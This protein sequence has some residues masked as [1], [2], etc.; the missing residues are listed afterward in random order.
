MAPP[1]EDSAHDAR[2]RVESVHGLYRQAF[3]N[4]WG[5]AAA[6]LCLVLVMWPFG[7]HSMLLGWLAV[8]LLVIAARVPLV[9]SYA[10]DTSRDRRPEVWARRYTWMVLANGS[11]WALASLL[12]LREGDPLAA[13][14]F[15]MIVGLLAAGS[16]ASQSYHLPAVLGFVSLA[17]LPLMLRLMTWKDWDYLPAAVTLLLFFL[18]LVA[19][20]RIQNRRI[21]DGIALRM[22]NQDL[23]AAL[24]REKEES[25]LQRARAEQ[26]SL[27][28]SQFLAA[29]SHDLRQPMHALGLFS[30]SLREAAKDAEQHAMV[31][32]ISASIESLES[33]FTELLDLSRLD[34]GYMQAHLVDIPLERVLGQLH[35]Q[36]A[37]L[38]TAKGLALTMDANGTVIRSDPVLLE[39]LLGNLVANAIQYTEHGR[40]SVSAT[41][42]GADIVVEVRD[43]GIGIPAA[44]RERVFDEFFQ[45]G[46][47]ERDRR[48]GLGLG[49]AI[50]RRLS[51]MLNHPVTLA[52]DEGKGSRFSVRIPSGD[53]QAVRPAQ[54]MPHLP[55][56]VLRG[57]VIL[58]LDNEISIRRGMEALL[59]R[60][61]CHVLSAGSEVEAVA[62]ATQSPPDLLIADLRLAAAS[63]GSDAI[64]AVSRALGAEVP[65]LI[66]TG[67]T[68][69]ESLQRARALGRP[70]LHKPVQPARLRAALSQLLVAPAVRA[71]HPSPAG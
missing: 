36:Y 47:P 19:N 49:L 7:V 57:K 16:I 1:V 40:V 55:A 25:D 32:N 64:Q 4:G 60:W 12:V 43:T 23:I 34:A 18:F 50:V 65:A 68:S 22:R 13:A 20:A 3:S 21:R 62:S 66:I 2:E 28:N 17:L 30:A 11:C 45:L 31:D 51:T 63:T 58:V 54:E 70:V 41:V 14:S 42:A 24:Q 37:A 53:P 9:R 48:K 46:N 5:A 61:G 52:S 35:A 59:G 38:A 6:A 44:Y 33:L 71:G 27:A 56:D 39:R 29:A 67:D 26:A 15:L 10:S 69:V 8:T